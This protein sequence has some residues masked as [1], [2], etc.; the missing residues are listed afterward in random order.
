MAF[1]LRGICKD[2][3][4]NTDR[5]RL[6]IRGPKGDDYQVFSFP[7]DYPF[8][9]GQIIKFLGEQ[10]GIPPGELIW[11]AYIKIPKA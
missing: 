6:L 3:P 1:Q 11:P 5:I 4:D 10:L 7:L 2:K 8:N 9:H